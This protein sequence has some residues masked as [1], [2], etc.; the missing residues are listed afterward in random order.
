M[1]N[2]GVVLITL[3]F[4]SCTKHTDSKPVVHKDL[5]GFKAIYITEAGNKEYDRL[6]SRLGKF[7]IRYVEDVIYVSTYAEVN[8]CKEYQGKMQIRNDTILLGYDYISDVA[9]TSTTI[10]KLTYLI[11]NPKKRKRIIRFE[12]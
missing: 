9:C 1:K 8:A 10:D 2:T 3:L 5:L 6:V 11:D 12:E 4:A 7:K